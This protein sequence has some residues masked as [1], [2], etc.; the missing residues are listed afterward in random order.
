[1]GHVLEVLAILAFKSYGWET[2][3]TCVDDGGQITL[4]MQIPCLDDPVQGHPD[5]ICRHENFTEN[6]WIPLE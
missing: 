6:A 4:E 5:G 2:R 3:H 1:M